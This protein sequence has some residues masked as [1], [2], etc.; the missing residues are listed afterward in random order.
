MQIQ[1]LLQAIT[2][3]NKNRNFFFMATFFTWACLG[4]VREVRTVHTLCWPAR[5]HLQSISSKYSTYRKFPIEM[6][7]WMPARDK[8]A[9]YFLIFQEQSQCVKKIVRWRFVIIF[10]ILTDFLRLPCG[11]PFQ[12]SD[13]FRETFIQI[14]LSLRGHRGRPQFSVR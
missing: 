1:I 13:F 2:T 12:N 7:V 6:W 8:N 3:A 11:K 14:E 4:S 10:P 9:K 5:I